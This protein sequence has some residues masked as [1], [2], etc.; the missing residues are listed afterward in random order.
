MKK[1]AAFIVVLF[2][3]FFAIG[4]GIVLGNYS[5]KT[6]AVETANMTCSMTMS[7]IIRSA[8]GDVYSDS[9]LSAPTT[10]SHYL[11]TYTV[12]GDKLTKPVLLE[13]VPNELK[14]EQKDTAIQQ[15]A[16]DI[17][18][19]LIPAQDRQMVVQYNVFTD[20]Y[21]NTLAAVDQNHADPSKWILEID[22]ADL[23]DEN[24]FLFTLIHEYAHL[25]TLNTSQVIPDQEIVN[26]PENQSLQHEKAAACPTYFAWTGCSNSDSYINAFYTRFWKDITPEW[27]AVDALQYNTDDLM[28]YYSGL[29]N[30]YMKHQ[31]QFVDD[32]S[33][34]HPTEDIAESFAYFVF[35]PKPNGTS[36]RDQKIAFFYEYPE[37][38][39]LRT[40]I[41]SG[42]CSL[43]K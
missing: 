10:A 25:L 24:S 11:V 8:Q 9:E 23:K 3:V 12:D 38:V 15:A 21:A 27:E 18:T 30:F 7:G 13:P 39:Q 34:T 40:D 14:I 32:Y 31:D 33:T 37:L 1:N 20:G 6:M 43:D 28:P 42:A 19:S 29:H 5:S 35:S 22:I 36:I 41:L 16:W 17:F 4:L 2:I 26:D